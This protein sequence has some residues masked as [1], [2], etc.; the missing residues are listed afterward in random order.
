MAEKK[1]TRPRSVRRVKAD[2]AAEKYQQDKISN[3]IKS[4]IKDTVDNDNLFSMFDEDDGGEPDEKTMSQAFV[5]RIMKTNVYEDIIDPY[6]Q[7]RGGLYEI[8]NREIMTMYRKFVYDGAWDAEKL[9][10]C[11]LFIIKS[12]NPNINRYA[13]SKIGMKYD[14]GDLPMGLLSGISQDDYDFIVNDVISCKEDR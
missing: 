7:S 2:R 9:F 1:K 12:G 13:L 3:V 10:N 14:N 8:I 5:G 4:A 6:V 11:L